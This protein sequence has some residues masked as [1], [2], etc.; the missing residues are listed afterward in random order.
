MHKRTTSIMTRLGWGAFFLVL[1]FLA[2]Q[3]MP[4][5]LGQRQS[6][7]IS[8]GSSD[9]EASVLKQQATPLTPAGL[10]ISGTLGTAPPGGATG[11][12][13]TRI[14]RPGTGPTATCAGVTWPGPFGAGPFIYN[15]HYFTN[16]TASPL[17]T[18]LTFTMLTQGPNPFGNMQLSAF[19]APFVAADINDSDRYLGDAG[20]SSFVPGVQT[21]F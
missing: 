18:P 3:V 12:L 1:L 16:N 8:K 4:P 13:A 14:N 2:V 10:P 6:A 5:A 20:A 21:T 17:C 9:V 19:K 15:V 11:N 7:D